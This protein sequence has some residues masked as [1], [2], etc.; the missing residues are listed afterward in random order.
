MSQSQA[1]FPDRETVAVKLSALSDADKQWL[2]LLLENPAQD[3]ALLDGLGLFINEAAQARF[4]NALKLSKAA[5]WLG[6]NAPA[7]LQMRLLET[8]RSSQHAAFVA[9]REGLMKTGGPDRAFPKA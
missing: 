7:R 9:F 1:P 8:A 5:E 4:L 2:K 3:D 6:E